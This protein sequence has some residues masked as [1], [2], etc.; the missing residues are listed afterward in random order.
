MASCFPSPAILEVLQLLVLLL[1]SLLCLN[2]IGVAND[3]LKAIRPIPPGLMPIPLRYIL[4]LTR[5]IPSG[6]MPIP[7]HYNLPPRSLVLTAPSKSLR[8][9]W[10]APSGV[11]VSC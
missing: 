2:H 9:K 8:Y 4:P 11:Q 10:S 1:V 3:A 7:L 6:L 5:P